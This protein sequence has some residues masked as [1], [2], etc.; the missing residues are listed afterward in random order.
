VTL[1]AR[2]IPVV[3]YESVELLTSTGNCSV[4]KKNTGVYCLRYWVYATESQIYMAVRDYV[5]YH[6]IAAQ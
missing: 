5:V 1:N 3:Q 2:Q 6:Y 4:S